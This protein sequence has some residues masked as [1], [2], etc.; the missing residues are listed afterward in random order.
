MPLTWSTEAYASNACATTALVRDRYDVPA[1][2]S[3]EA[4]H[5][6]PHMSHPDA[7]SI[8]FLQ[9]AIMVLERN[10]RP[11]TTGEITREA[12]HLGLLR[13][14]GKTPVKTMDA[15]LYG[16]ARHGPKVRVAR[17]YAPG[18]QRAVRGSVRWTLSQ[19][20]GD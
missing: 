10:G 4:W 5:V 20:G 11:M 13:T 1:R 15:A 16:Q 19:G 8:S 14:T 6:R 18:R 17:L 7:T 2:L 3:F 12:L 9:A